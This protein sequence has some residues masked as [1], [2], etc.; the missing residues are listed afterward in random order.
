MGPGSMFVFAGGLYLCAVAA[1]LA[2]PKELAN[3]RRDHDDDDD[4]VL[5]E[6]QEDYIPLYEASSLR[7][8]VPNEDSLRTNRSYG[9]T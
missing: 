2:L 3:S 1:A 4:V 9:S 8:G 5:G 7:D 6:D